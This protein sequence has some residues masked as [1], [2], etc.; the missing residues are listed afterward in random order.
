MRVVHDACER[1]REVRGRI[2]RRRVRQHV[3]EVSRD[4]PLH[5]QLG[6]LRGWRL[7]DWPI[8]D[9]AEVH[10]RPRLYL[11]LRLNSSHVQ[12]RD[13]HLECELLL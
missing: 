13:L 10:L 12:R 5:R 6:L 2:L 3:Q 9:R 1:R 8:R 11:P 7:P 4:E